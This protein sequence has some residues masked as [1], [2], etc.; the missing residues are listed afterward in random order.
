MGLISAR[1]IKAPL[2]NSGSK[3]HKKL[4]YAIF[5]GKQQ[6]SISEELAL[7][8]NRSKNSKEGNGGNVVKLKLN[9][10]RILYKKQSPV[11]P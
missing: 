8:Q 3:V 6:D 2:L 4:N 10:L 7:Y 9:Y 1:I 11:L 5:W